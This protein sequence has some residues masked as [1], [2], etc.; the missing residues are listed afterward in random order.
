MP[1]LWRAYV[2]AVEAFCFAGIGAILVIG[3]M[4]VVWRYVFNSSLFWSEEAMR[5]LMIWIVMIGA[6]LSYSRGQFLGMRLAVDRLP[7]GLRRGADLVSAVLMLVFLAAILWFGTR[8]AW[9]TRL[10]TA[11]A[12][13]FS[14]FWVHVAISVGALLLALHVA[15]NEFFG[16][17]REEKPDEHP[18][19]AEEAL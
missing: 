3:T 8:F 1:K 9:M 19:G 14:L 17:A 13:G 2:A 16:I 10:Q 18:M 4:Q 6:G 7:A 15:L 11:T 12:L 5:Y